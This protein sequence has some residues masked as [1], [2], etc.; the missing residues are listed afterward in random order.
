MITRRVTPR[1]KWY[2]LTLGRLHLSCSVAKGRYGFHDTTSYHIG[3]W[4]S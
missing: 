2:V 3:G 1:E 4:W